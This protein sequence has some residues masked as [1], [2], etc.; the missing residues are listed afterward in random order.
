M[1]VV[2]DSSFSGMYSLK[3]ARFLS[4]WIAVVIAS[5]FFSDDF[6]HRVVVNNDNPRR[7]RTMLVVWAGIQA[8]FEVMIFTAMSLLSIKAGGA[9]GAG[10]M[11][12]RFVS[13]YFADVACTSS[14]ALGLGLVVA[15]VLGNRQ[16]FDYVT[17]GSRAA[18]TLEEIMVNIVAVVYLIPFFL[19]V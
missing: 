18:R 8:C 12:A 6:V 5:K 2:I 17:Q 19:L 9:R 3:L 13:A 4:A 7:L 1:D 11:D 10:F 15:S 14:L 16:R